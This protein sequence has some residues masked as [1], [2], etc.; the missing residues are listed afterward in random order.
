METLLDRDIFKKEVFARDSGMCVIPGCGKPAVDAHHI[1]E[2]SLFP[3]GGY[4]LSNGASVCAEHHIACEMT[5][6][7]TKDLYSYTGITIPVLPPHFFDDTEYDKWGNPVML[8]G[9][10]MRGELFWD[11]SFQ[12]ILQQT[13]IL[14]LFTWFSKYPRTWHLPW[15]LGLGEDDRVIPSLDNFKGKRIIVSLKM[16][17]ENSSLYR[18]YFHARS[19][20]GRHHPSRDWLKRFWAERCYDIPEG[21]RING[22]NLYARHT[23]HYDALPSYFFGFS[24]WNDRNICFAW[25]EMIEWFNL[26][27]IHPVDVIYDGIFDEKKLLEIANTGD[28][29]VNEG[30]VMRLADAFP[31]RDFNKSVSKFVRKNHVQTDK[32]WM[33]GEIIK[34]KLI[35]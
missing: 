6:I 34:N 9:L 29:T 30:Y 19:I 14:D 32:H 26:F 8:S 13:D 22:E 20:D 4:Y 5:L 28:W 24:M 35:S 7:S 16:D 23:L 25:D 18:D 12:K 10:R 15:S 11:E 2:R 33:H 3:D 31:F 27:N 1:L 21:W 17:G